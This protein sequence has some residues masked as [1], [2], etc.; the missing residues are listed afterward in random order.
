M[1]ESPSA[2]PAQGRCRKGLEPLGHYGRFARQAHAVGARVDAVEGFVDGSETALDC[3]S[4]SRGFVIDDVV[5]LVPRP[6]GHRNPQL[7]EETAQPVALTQQSRLLTPLT[8]GMRV[9]RSLPDTDLSLPG[10][11]WIVSDLGSRSTV[12]PIR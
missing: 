4:V 8:A 10:F 5:G 11:S 9:H 12:S 6:T 2:T 7:L 3:H 1:L